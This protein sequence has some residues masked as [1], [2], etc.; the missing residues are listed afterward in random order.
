MTDR[1]RSVLLAQKEVAAL[2]FLRVRVS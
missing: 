1:R 2:L